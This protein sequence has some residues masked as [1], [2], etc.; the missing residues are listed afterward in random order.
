MKPSAHELSNQA[1]DQIDASTPTAVT[2]RSF[3]TYTSVL[4]GTTLFGP[5]PLFAG[6]P[7]QSRS[8]SL[9][10]KKIA[11]FIKLRRRQGIIAPDERTA[12]SVY[13]FATQ[14]KLVS[15][16]ED[17]PLQS[18]SMIKPFIALA[19]FYRV[20]EGHLRFQRKHRRQLEA[21]IRWS[22]NS[23]TNYF[24]DLVCRRKGN[25]REVERVLKTNA[26][27]IFRHTRIVEYIP[28]DGKAYRNLASARD[29][30]RFLYALWRNKLPYSQEIK[31]LMRLPNRDRIGTGVVGIPSGIEV[32]DK[33]GT[34]AQLCGDMGILVPKSKDGRRYPY[35]II[36]IIEK[37]RRAQYF[38]A[39]TASR[40][41]IIREVSSMTYL[42]IKHMHGLA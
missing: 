29:Y 36:G 6:I 19:F 40:G 5:S 35:T 14:R 4:L 30:S 3:L 1:L 7:R 11:G 32:Y 39:W 23:A 16:N 18:A 22:S 8:E 34:T 41:D 37:S 17:T 42:H 24:I 33:T 26:P 2:R 13:D 9:L 25:P 28:R 12:W 15:I 38:Q 21:M 31:R 10:E 27:A 20:K